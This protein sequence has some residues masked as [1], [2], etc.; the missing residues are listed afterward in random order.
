MSTTTYGVL[1]FNI[2]TSQW[3]QFN[4]TNIIGAFEPNNYVN[5]IEYNPQDDYIFAGENYGNSKSLVMFPRDGIIKQLQYVYGDYTTQWNF[6]THYPLTVDYGSSQVSLSIDEEDSLYAFWADYETSKILWAKENSSLYFDKYLVENEVLSIARDINGVPNTLEFTLSHGHLFDPSNINSLLAVYAKKGRKVSVR[7]GELINGLRIFADQGTFTITETKIN[8]GV[9]TYPT[10]SISASDKRVFWEQETIGA[11]EFYTQNPKE[12]LENMLNT[13][14]DV[15][16]EYYDIPVFDDGISLQYQFIDYNLLDALN[17]VCTR[18]GYFLKINSDD[19]VTAI[20]IDVD[21][22]SENVY[23]DNTRLLE[24]TPDDSYSDFTNRVVVTG[25]ELNPVEMV[26]D[27]ERITSFN[28]T[29]G[30]WRCKKEH[31]VW[32]SDDRSRMC[33]NPRLHTIVSA[34]TMMFELAGGIDED[35]IAVDQEEKNCTV[36]IDAPNLIP[37][38]LGGIAAYIVGSK[39]PDLLNNYQNITVPMG[40]LVEQIAIVAI[41]NVLGSI[42][43]YQYDI[44]AQPIG[45]VR[46][47]VQGEANDIEFKSEIGREVT[48]FLDGFL[49][50]TIGHCIKVAEFELLIR[51]LQ[52]QRINFTKITH[53][54]DEEGDKITVKHPYTNNNV[55]VL[56]TKLVREYKHG[57]ECSVLD[58]IEGWR[59]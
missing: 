50:Y 12:A 7:I 17:D 53:L 18:F 23:T 59:V 16:P 19:S 21:K 35:I 31:V 39:I 48:E 14:C 26:Y 40:R 11:S 27:E 3:E 30:W 24:Y 15:P 1:I 45:F 58:R 13:F 44:Y 28:G 47:E 8:Y 25:Q 38:L 22:A 34:T 52:R 33:R 43:N 46:R 10:I 4:N 6:G 29:I 37:M 51:Q 2:Y 36:I 55:N 41:F 32:Y 54:Q 56:I 49:C 9:D 5:C 57:D 20:K 42:V